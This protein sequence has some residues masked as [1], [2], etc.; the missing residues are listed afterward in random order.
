MRWRNVEGGGSSRSGQRATGPRRR[1]RWR[2]VPAPP[3]SAA[4]AVAAVLLVLAP[5]AAGCGGSTPAAS[6]NQPST[7]TGGPTPTAPG[8]TVPSVA[9]V[10]PGNGTA[11][12]PTVTVRPG[13]STTAPAAGGRPTLHVTALGLTVT[14]GI[15]LTPLPFGAPRDQVVA[16]LSTVLG[17]AGA[18][19][20]VGP[21]CRNRA[22]EAIDWPGQLRVD[23]SRGTLVS[24]R[25]DHGSPITTD[26]GFGLGAT[27]A[28]VEGVLAIAVSDTSLGV[29][30]TTDS[31][32]P[33]LNGLLSDEGPAA[34][35]TE[36]WAGP[37]CAAR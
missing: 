10:P 6:P 31:E 18:P 27:R 19:Q 13:A 32:G 28:Q 11:A 26:S 22:D 15:D 17:G 20:P 3:T 4:V 34:T 24:W 2:L 8:G 14:A 33:L 35:V 7:A 9:T 5:G 16:A 36:L 1:A 25:L 29:E 12:S 21:E 37:V 30:F 23:F